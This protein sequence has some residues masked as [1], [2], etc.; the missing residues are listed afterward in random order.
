MTEILALPLRV[1]EKIGKE[2]KLYGEASQFPHA[3]LNFSVKTLV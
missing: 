1:V 2:E 3:S